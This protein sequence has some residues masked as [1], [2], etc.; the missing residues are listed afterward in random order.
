MLTNIAA[1]Y[2]FYCLLLTVT[3]YRHQ[4]K[5]HHHNEK[6]LNYGGDKTF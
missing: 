6:G 4:V 3:K 1:V 2:S 5:R